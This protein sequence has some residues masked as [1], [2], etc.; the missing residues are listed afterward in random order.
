MFY[1]VTLSDVI[2]GTVF[3]E[4]EK[5]RNGTETVYNCA[6]LQS[7]S[8]QKSS[9]HYKNIDF[10]LKQN[11]IKIKAAGNIFLMLPAVILHKLTT[12]INIRHPK[13]FG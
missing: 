8:Y 7:V 9:D 1:K 10:N 2:S 5:N 11:Y 12:V 13:H 3:R 6:L 4:F